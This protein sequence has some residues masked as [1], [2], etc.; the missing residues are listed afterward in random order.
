MLDLL[1]MV[2]AQEVSM[3]QIPEWRR[4][5]GYFQIHRKG[6]GMSFWPTETVEM[7]EHSFQSVWSL[8]QVVLGITP[9]RL[10]KA[11]YRSHQQ[12]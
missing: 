10:L 5:R 9:E 4:R 7:K 3:R 2:V 11:E 12:K 6:R 1:P 8:A